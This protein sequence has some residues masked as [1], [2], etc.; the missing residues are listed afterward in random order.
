MESHVYGYRLF[1]QMSYDMENEEEPRI[2]EHAEMRIYSL[3]T[4]KT[5]S[6]RKLLTTI[7]I[8]YWKIRC[9]RQNIEQHSQRF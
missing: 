6:L 4:A 1:N 9:R 2:D 7:S 3:L 8:G 5:K